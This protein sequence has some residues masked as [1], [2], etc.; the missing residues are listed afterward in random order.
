MIIFQNFCEHFFQNRI[1][2]MGTS[3]T[4]PNKP[5]N[6]YW[7]RVC[8]HIVGRPLFEKIMLLII[9]CN[10]GFTLAEIFCWQTDE[11]QNK[12]LN[13]SLLAAIWIFTAIYI[14]EF[15]MKIMAFSWIHVIAHGFRNY[16]K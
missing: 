4:I 1:E 12:S 10:L 11:I 14:L 7:R 5:P 6:T 15:V 8:Y 16:F 2:H 9:L 13:I 3:S